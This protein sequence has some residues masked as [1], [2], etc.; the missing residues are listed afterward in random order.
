MNNE[1]KI[2]KVMDIVHSICITHTFVFEAERTIK[3]NEFEITESNRLVLVANLN[4]MQK[5]LERDKIKL[6]EYLLKILND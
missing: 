3:R 4:T 1:D 5:M 2:E 6:K